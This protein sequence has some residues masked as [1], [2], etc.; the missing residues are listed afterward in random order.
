MKFKLIF[1]IFNAIV[2]FS[3]LFISMLPVLM[4]GWEYAAPFWQNSWYLLLLFVLILATLDSYFIINWKLFT[5]MEKRDW[6]EIRRYLEIQIFEKSRLNE[7]H[8]QILLNTYVV[9]SESANI[10]RLAGYLKDTRPRLRFRLQLSLGIGYML[11]KDYRG[12][13][14]FFSGYVRDD[15]LVKS[16]WADWYMAFGML[17]CDNTEEA[18][19]R[20][21][22]I[23]ERGKD[24]MVVVLALYLLMEIPGR[25]SDKA[26][27]WLKKIGEKY[28]S[29]DWAQKLES[30]KDR[31]HVLA[32]SGVL[33]EAGEWVVAKYN[34]DMPTALPTDEVS[35][36]DNIPARNES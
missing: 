14:D 2:L 24:D 13:R 7:Q 31:L 23:L 20:L 30:R 19:R 21:E 6:D 15:K 1:F 4:L 16:G 27:R 12:L 33:Q 11:E 32:L 36:E 5:L 22:F 8:L 29:A 25:D 34:T 18:A 26:D 17:R 35:R 10:L 3:F 9:K 28:S